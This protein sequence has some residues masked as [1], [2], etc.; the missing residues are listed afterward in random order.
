MRPIRLTMSAFGPYAGEVVVD[1][2]KLGRSGLYLITGDTGAGK[3]TIFDAVTYALYGSASGE[4]REVSM[5]RSEYAG[6]ATPTFV[7]LCFAYGDKEYTVRRSPDYERAKTRGEGTTLQKADA[8]LLYPDGRVV[9]KTREVTAAVTEIIGV[10]RDQFTRI[11]MIAQGDFLKLL[12]ASTEERKAIFRH[13]FDTGLYRTFQDRL[14]D[15]CAALSRQ[16]EELLVSVEQY[17]GGIRCGDGEE[18]IRLLEEI[19]SGR[20]SLGETAEMLE[21][22]LVSDETEEH[23]LRGELEEMERRIQ[24]LSAELGKAEERAKTEKSLTAVET[25]L[26]EHSSASAELAAALEQQQ[27][28]Q[29]E[30]D[31]LSGFIAAVTDELP[32]YAELDTVRGELL[33]KESARTNLERKT[34]ALREQTAEHRRVMAERKAEAE[35][36][37]DSAVL[38]SRMD[39]A[40]ADAQRERD[41]LL[42]LG[43]KLGEYA[44]LC[45]KLE[46]ARGSYRAAADEAEVRTAE[47][48]RQNRAFLDEQAGILAETL[49][50]GRPCPVCGSMEHP[51]PAKLSSDAP[52]KHELER[53]RLAC[54]E[55]RQA[56]SDA[57]AKAAELAGQAS[58]CRSEVRERC[59]DIL[60][61]CETEQA[62]S[63]LEV[64]LSDLDSR[65][66]TLRHDRA[67]A[68][69]DAVRCEELQA[70][71]PKMERQ[72]VQLEQDLTEQER[73]MTVLDTELIERRQLL[74]ALSSRLRYRSG[75]E[76][77]RAV[78]DAVEKQKKLR[79]TLRKAREAYEAN[80]AEVNSLRG[81][82]DALRQRLAELPVLDAAALSG[83]RS[84]LLHRKEKLTGQLTA[85]AT[86]L[87]G[88]REALSGIRRRGE[89]LD[90]TEQKLRWMRSLANTAGGTLSGKEKVMLETYVQMT[91]FDRVIR[92]ANIRFMVMSGG[93]YELRRRMTAE[94]NRSQSGLELSVIDHYN[95]SERSVKSLSGGESFKAS[96]ALALGLSDEI[97]SSAGGVR[98]DAMFVDE[99]FGSLDEASL[100]QAYRALAELSEGKR[101]VGIISHVAAL[102]EKIDRQ[103]VVTKKRTGGSQVEIIV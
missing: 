82:Q 56:A 15:T 44:D 61:G 90:E 48:E 100:D 12:L 19:K 76:A 4:N 87:S 31:E 98:L 13:I 18:D 99:G 85:L 35:E 57:S 70:V 17:I 47:Y 9:T 42:E 103:I 94:N 2:N 39:A 58:R 63:L 1:F 93:Q 46:K 10:S 72:L 7:E 38:L 91:F 50:A 54:E 69:K 52:D 64:R 73:G 29:R 60:G 51:L 24:Q 102:K 26:A 20:P 84:E 81:Q 32:R 101:V 28:W 25:S 36:L 5:L 6:A 8:Q 3:T 62:D 83:G 97:Q 65:L 53:L 33:A 23:A 75:E 55:S 22:L 49:T 71:L 30:S 66:E 16:R 86:R 11:A 78:S 95:G 45:G 43:D 40:L 59:D 74:A 88:N 34:A 37:Q 14:K 96:L 21:Q 89:S 67:R 68:E 79:E 92:R 27:E 41:R 77:E 80:L